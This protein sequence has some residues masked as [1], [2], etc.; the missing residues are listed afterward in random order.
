[1]ATTMVRLEMAVGVRTLFCFSIL[2]VVEMSRSTVTV[3]GAGMGLTFGN[4]RGG[5]V[6]ATMFGCGRVCGNGVVCMK[7]GGAMLAP[8]GG[9]L[10]LG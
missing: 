4:G 6:T 9:R 7:G 3:V 2:P 5:E 1:M 8:G 10:P